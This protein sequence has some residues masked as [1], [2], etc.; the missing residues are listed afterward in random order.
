MT[1]PT[2]QRKVRKKLGRFSLQAALVLITLVS[3]LMVVVMVTYTNRY[4]DMRNALLLLEKNE[5]YFGMANAGDIPW[6]DRL[7]GL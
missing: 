3:L 1:E 6:Y 4:R 2:D 5:I 7:P